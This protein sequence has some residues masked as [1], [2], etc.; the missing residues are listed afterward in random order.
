MKKI[1]ILS[2]CVLLLGSSVA[3]AQ[4]T[5]TTTKQKN[6]TA[7]LNLPCIQ[8][9][10]S[11]RETAI[12]GSFSTFSSS[13]S[14]DL[15]ARA[16]AL[17]TAWGLTDG[18]ARKAARKAAWDAYKNASEKARTTFKASKQTAWD[19]F[20]TASAACKVPVVESAANDNL[21]I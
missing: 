11:N 15:S 1:I 18:K 21:A 19:A 14:A 20:K 17:S 3:F 12:A 8:T 6:T 4:T 16:S 5:N 7:T 9:A 2:L 13:V 10:V